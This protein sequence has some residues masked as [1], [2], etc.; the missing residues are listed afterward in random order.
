MQVPNEDLMTQNVYAHWVIQDQRQY[1]T[2]IVI[3]KK[4]EVIMSQRTAPNCLDIMGP[5][6]AA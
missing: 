4:L 6:V 5:V 1:F 3:N 2:T